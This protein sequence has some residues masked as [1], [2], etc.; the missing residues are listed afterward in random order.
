RVGWI[1]KDSVRE[2]RQNPYRS[3]SHS[4]VERVGAG[5][6]Y[7]DVAGQ[8]QHPIGICVRKIRRIQIHML[9]RP[10]IIEG[11]NIDQGLDLVAIVHSEQIAECRVAGLLRVNRY[12][13]VEAKISTVAKDR[14]STDAEKLAFLGIANNR[15]TTDDGSNMRPDCHRAPNLNE[16]DG[17]S[18]V[19]RLGHN[20]LA[21]GAKCQ[22]A[23][24]AQPANDLRYGGLSH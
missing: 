21:A 16:R 20:E 17:N 24:T 3:V 5:I 22:P 12:Y 6:H 7:I 11:A 2:E 19:A 8:H 9:C 10:V 23:R 14:D 18:L 15:E 4:L 1:G 13:G